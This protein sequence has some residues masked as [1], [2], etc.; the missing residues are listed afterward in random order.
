MTRITVTPGL[1][2]PASPAL[3]AI[4]L[5]PT[6][7]P[8]GAVKRE[9][10]DRLT[11]SYTPLQIA[12]LSQTYFDL[13]D[14]GLMD[15]L[16]CLIIRGKTL[17]DSLINWVPGGA[18]VENHG[19]TLSSSGLAGNGVDQWL[20]LKY[21][22]GRRYQMT[23]ACHF[24]WV[25]EFTVSASHQVIGG[26]PTPTA[27]VS[28][29]YMTAGGGA[30]ARL[31]SPTTVTADAQ[32]DPA[33][34]LWAVTRLNDSVSIRRGAGTLITQNQSPT[35][36]PNALALYRE[37]STFGAH[38]VSAAGFGGNLSETFVRRLNQILADHHRSI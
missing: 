1:W 36:L 30:G 35:A 9:I 37:G 13:I 21:A 25:Q 6:M 24:A 29:L 31:G 12:R 22:A 26:G 3:S 11:G 8:A 23:S 17:A 34:G 7:P 28:R 2:A 5:R 20:D 16:D 14:S 33:T 18:A 4:N 15:L 27:G 19:V 38:T 32:P 10:L